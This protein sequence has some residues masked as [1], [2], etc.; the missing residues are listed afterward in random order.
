MPPGS[1]A[2]EVTRDTCFHVTKG[3]L[4]S[5]ENI[6]VPAEEEAPL[7]CVIMNVGEA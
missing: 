6:F 1:A 7:F 2:V 4:G 3:T 5:P